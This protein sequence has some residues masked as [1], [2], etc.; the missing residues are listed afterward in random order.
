MTIP[1]PDLT[2][3]QFATKPDFSV[4]PDPDIDLSGHVVTMI[5]SPWKGGPVVASGSAVVTA[6]GLT[7]QWRGSGDTRFKGLHRAIFENDDGLRLP[8]NKSYIVEVIE[9]PGDAG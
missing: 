8:T 4:D 6:S 2:I 7:Y 3:P 1:E 9:A 5:M